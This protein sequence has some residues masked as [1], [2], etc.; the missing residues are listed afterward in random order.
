MDRMIPAVATID[1]RPV[2]DFARLA[3]KSE[4]RLALSE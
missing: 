4:M 2:L 3:T 1:E